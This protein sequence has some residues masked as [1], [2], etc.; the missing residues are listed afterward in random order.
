MLSP[1]GILCLFFFALCNC[2]LLKKRSF[3]WSNSRIV[4]RD[5]LDILDPSEMPGS[6]A[7]KQRQK[8]VLHR[9]FTATYCPSLI[10]SCTESFKV[11]TA[12][13]VLVCGVKPYWFLLIRLLEC[14]WCII[15]LMSIFSSTLAAV[16]IKLIGR[17]F[18]ISSQVYFPGFKM[19]ISFALF[20]VLGKHVVLKHPLYIAV[21]ECSNKL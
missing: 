11:I 6:L 5:F 4:C 18:V 3:H 12:P 10:L 1:V 2:S 21:V 17:Y 20:H 8:L 13:T 7:T 9:E 16:L 14:I 15:L 19:G